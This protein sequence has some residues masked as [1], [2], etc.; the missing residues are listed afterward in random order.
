MAS[1]FPVFDC[2]IGDADSEVLVDARIH[3]HGS[4]PYTLWDRE[5]WPVVDLRFDIRP[6]SYRRVLKFLV[7]QPSDLENLLRVLAAATPDSWLEARSCQG[8]IERFT[9]QT[10]PTYQEALARLSG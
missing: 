8:E 2:E 3:G 1:A 4:L 10:A 6:S 9:P 7:F 5:P